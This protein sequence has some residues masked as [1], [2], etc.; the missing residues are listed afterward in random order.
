M[1]RILAA[2]AALLGLLAGLFGLAAPAQATNPGTISG[3]ETEG[4]AVSWR[5]SAVLDS[6]LANDDPE[7]PGLMTDADGNPAHFSNGGFIQEVAPALGDPGILGMHHFY[8]G[9]GSTLTQVWRIPVATDATILDASVTFTLPPEMAGQ[10]VT[11]D[12]VS[13][14]SRMSSWGAPYS[15]YTWSP[16]AVA[17]DNGDGTWTVDL[18]DLARGQATV[19]QFAIPMA[20]T[21]FVQTDRFIGSATLAG[22][23]APGANGGACPIT[24]AP[25]APVPTADLP[26]CT[27]EY[28]GRTLWTVYSRDIDVRDKVTGTTSGDLIGEVN[29]D[30]WGAGAEAWGAGATRTYR[31][32]AATTVELLDVTYVVDAVQGMTFDLAQIA[33]QAN[34]PGGGMLQAN[35]YT[36]AVEGVT[37][38]PGAEQITI[39]IDRMPAN[40]SLSLTAG[41]ILDGT[42]AT[43]ALDHRLIGTVAGC[44]PPETVTTETVETTASCDDQ[45]V[46][47]VTTTT[48]AAGVWNASTLSFDVVESVTA[49][50][51]VRPMTSEEAALCAAG[52][53]P[54]T[55]PPATTTATTPPGT[56]GAPAAGSPGAPLVVTGAEG[57]P[58]LVGAS[59]ALIALG[60]AVRMILVRR[61]R[62]ASQAEQAD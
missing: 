40:S 20:G 55:T 35:G 9:S 4:C 62:G 13:T 43:M 24:D 14:N 1:K 7:Y 36:A 48:T 5:S 15:A 60:I 45:T 23:Y 29:A 34:T 33:T 38:T 51:T 25:P 28:L 57:L 39:H 58:L 27:A 16:R 49:S 30:G 54:P 21:G 12:A 3:N 44:T 37:I 32:Y 47:E 31:L 8:V 22:T 11:F 59:L 52:T 6:D 2:L 50:R 61:R 46:A 41:A 26:A 42:G 10:P 53:T 19:F 17:V 56:P 18:G